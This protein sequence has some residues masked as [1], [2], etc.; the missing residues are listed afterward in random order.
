MKK[1]F[2]IFYGE[3][4][5]NP[6]DGWEGY[7][8]Q[9][10]WHK[11]NSINKLPIAFLDG[12]HEESPYFCMNARMMNMWFINKDNYEW[13]LLCISVHES[14]KEWK[15][16]LLCSWILKMNEEIYF[17]VHES[18]KWM[19]KWVF[20]WNMSFKEKG[21]NVKREKEEHFP[22]WQKLRTWDECSLKVFKYIY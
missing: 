22:K 8:G 4:S 18:W 7:F 13:K 16:I 20:I 19:K 6:R 17:C 10:E 12:Y 15:N 3:R 9:G 2:E 14:W 11:I 5:L 21:M 1:I